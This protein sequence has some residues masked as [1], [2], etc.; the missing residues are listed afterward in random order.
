M[1]TGTNSLNERCE[2]LMAAYPDDAVNDNPD[3]FLR[4]VKV[5]YAFA[6]AG[7]G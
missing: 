4:R 3:E 5:L 1:S 2:A 7:G 6:T